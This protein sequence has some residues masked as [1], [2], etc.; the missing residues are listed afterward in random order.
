MSTGSVRDDWGSLHDPSHHTYFYTSKAGCLNS[1]RLPSLLPCTTPKNASACTNRTSMPH[2]DAALYSKN[3]KCIVQNKRRR[4]PSLLQKPN[5][6][7]ELKDTSRR[8]PSKIATETAGL[9]SSTHH[10]S[11]SKRSMV[12]SQKPNLA[13][14]V[15]SS[16]KKLPRAA[17]FDKVLDPTGEKISLL[18]FL[19]AF[20]L[21]GY[22]TRPLFLRKIELD[23]VSA[24]ILRRVCRGRSHR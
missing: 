3:T 2:K 21:I 12:S 14:M 16:N 10:R 18:P 15:I 17:E 19:I 9:T 11:Q 23:H 6:I 24:K 5:A 1:R 13:I 7:L 22:W 20:V 8:P 4:K